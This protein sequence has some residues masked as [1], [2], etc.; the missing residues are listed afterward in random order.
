MIKKI[1]IFCGLIGYGSHAYSMEHEDVGQLL[2]AAARTAG[3]VEVSMADHGEKHKVIEQGI[4]ELRKGLIQL[5]AQREGLV[6]QI[7][8]TQKSNLEHI[9]QIDTAVKEE[10]L[11]L[12]SIIE[13]LERSS[14]STLNEHHESTKQEIV[15]LK[16]EF[17]EITRHIKEKTKAKFA[18]LKPQ[19]L[20]QLVIQQQQE[21]DKLKQR[22]ARYCK[23]FVKTVIV[24]LLVVGL[25]Y[26][27]ARTVDYCYPE[28]PSRFSLW[29]GNFTID[30]C[31]GMKRECPT[32]RWPF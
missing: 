31:F 1:V 27:L 4:Q 13:K 26:S 2:E 20:R 3:R 30:G 8:L 18:E 5:Q 9:Q 16:Q 32:Y 17:S 14:A 15:Q 23:R 12:Q 22:P 28:C 24:L 21:I 7:D 29:G 19:E 25:I 6:S 10:M 11:R